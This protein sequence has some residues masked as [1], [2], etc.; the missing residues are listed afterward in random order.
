MS[1]RVNSRVRVAVAALLAA[2]LL[3]ASVNA[4]EPTEPEPPLPGTSQPQKLHEW[5]PLVSAARA[6]AEGVKVGAV[7]GFDLLILRPLSLTAT[8]V[9]TALFIPIAVVTAPNGLDSVEEAME[10]FVMTPAK[11][12]FQRDLGDF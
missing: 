8:I 5:P 2:T 7:K 6:T 3:P 11:A 12:T 10:I 9:G 4:Q 1:Q